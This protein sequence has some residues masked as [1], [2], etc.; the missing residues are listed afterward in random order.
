MGD[1][2]LTTQTSGPQVDQPLARSF[3]SPLHMPLCAI[4]L[5][6]EGSPTKETTLSKCCLLWFVLGGPKDVFRPGHSVLH[7]STLRGSL[8]SDDATLKGSWCTSGQ[9]TPSVSVMR[10]NTHIVAAEA[11]GKKYPSE[12]SRAQ[13]STAEHSRAQPS[14]AEHSRHRAMNLVLTSCEPQGF[15]ALCIFVLAGDVTQVRLAA[16]CT[17]AAT[18]R[19]SRYAGNH[20]RE[21][22]S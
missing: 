17:A 16:S 21:L 14:T 22:F 11:A 2:K 18:L 20:C 15:V 9:E 10:G 8:R 7:C 12:H 6:K 3:M 13:P 1:L 4:A 19:A 5:M